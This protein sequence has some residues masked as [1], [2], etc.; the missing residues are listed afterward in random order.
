MYSLIVVDYNSIEATCR[1]IESYSAC[2]KNGPVHAV[3]VDNGNRSDT[4]S[5]A[6]AHM[7]AEPVECTFEGRTLWRF[8]TGKMDVIYCASGEN[9]GYA[10]GNNLGVRIADHFFADPYYIISNNDLILPEELD[11][12]AVTDWFEKHPETAVI[13]PRV[14]GVDGIAQSPRKDQSA[15]TKLIGWYWCMGPLKKWVDDICHSAQEG[16]CDWIMGCFMVIRA[17]AFR[18]VGGFD[19]NTFLFAEEMI[20]S[21]RLEKAGLQVCYVPAFTVIHNH[22]ATVKK[23]FAVQQGFQLSFDSNC[24]YYK[25]YRN[26]S[27]FLLTFAKLN[28]AIYKNLYPLRQMLKKRH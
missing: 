5:A 8:A 13:G 2:L 24:Y 17:D 15:F 18:Q 1:Y 9:M 26:A 21:A 23:T 6:R 10:R 20:L 14:V 19:E 16:P 3:I 12:T 25:H 7:A 27:A 4:L 28:F 22:N 11:L